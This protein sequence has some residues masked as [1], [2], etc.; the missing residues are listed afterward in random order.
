MLFSFRSADASKYPKMLNVLTLEFPT[1]QKALAR[2]IR[3]GS[4][5]YDETTGDVEITE[6]AKPRVEV[7]GSASEWPDIIGGEGF[8]ENPV[9]LSQRIVTAFEEHGITGWKARP[10]ELVKKS[11]RKLD[12]RTAPQYF[13]IEITGRIG[14]YVPTCLK[15]KDV[16]PDLSAKLVAA[17]DRSDIFCEP[18]SELGRWA[19]YCS[20]KV[21][22][23]ARGERWTNCGFQPLQ[24]F[25]PFHKAYLEY[26]SAVS[27]S[28]LVERYTRCL[29]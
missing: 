13:F 22:D 17:W 9:M 24:Y 21:F 18:S 14:M 1:T 16:A 4:A 5:R 15:A 28:E 29:E 27:L 7:F 2:M 20:E 6:F 10:V 11:S 19:L 25:A 3:E 8:T 23:L 12:V 26:E